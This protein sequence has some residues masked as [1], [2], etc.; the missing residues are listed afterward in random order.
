MPTNTQEAVISNEVLASD[1]KSKLD[2]VTSE[3]RA[4]L[5]D[6]INRIKNITKYVSEFLKRGTIL[7]VGSAP[8]LVVN[9][10]NIL[11]SLE[12]VIQREKS[13]GNKK[14]VSID[15]DIWSLDALKGVKMTAVQEQFGATIHRFTQKVTHA[16][17]LEEA[18]KLMV[19]KDWNISEAW[20]IIIAGILA[21]EVDTNG[22][23]IFAYFTVKVQDEDILYRF[24]A[25]RAYNGQLYVYVSLVH[26]DI[27][28][29]AGDGVVLG[30]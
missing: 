29:D 22:T 10:A 9:E 12:K 7:T 8:E 20:N 30:N 17:V 15:K 21:G 26:Q 28:W 11:Q 25:S 27:M 14:D 3:A 13:R 2:S 16:K 6:A 24:R 19:K 4:I 18:D 23:G 1:L 5:E